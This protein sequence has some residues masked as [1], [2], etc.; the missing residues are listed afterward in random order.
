MERS[1]LRFWPE[2][3]LLVLRM[4]PFSLTGTGPLRDF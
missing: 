4:E 1:R 3:A 2:V